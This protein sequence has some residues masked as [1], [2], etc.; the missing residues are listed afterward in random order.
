[1][2]A[3]GRSCRRS[4]DLAALVGNRR[5][6]SL[7]I[8]APLR[9][10][11]LPVGSAGGPRSRSEGAAAHLDLFGGPARARGRDACAV[12]TRTFRATRSG[13]RTRALRGARHL[14]VLDRFPSSPARAR[15]GTV[16]LFLPE[17]VAPDVGSLLE[18]AARLAAIAVEQRQLT[19]QL[20]PGPL[21]PADEPA[22]PPVPRG[23][24]ADAVSHAARRAERVTLLF[25]DLDRFKRVND[26]FGH[27]GGDALHAG[28]APSRRRGGRGDLVARMG[29]DEFCVLRVRPGALPVTTLARRLLDALDAPFDIPGE[30]VVVGASVGVSM[31]PDDAHDA[32]ALQM[33][34]DAAMYAAKQETGRACHLFQPGQTF[35]GGDRLRIDN[36]LRRAIAAG[37]LRLAFQPQADLDGL[38]KG[39]E[40]L[41]RWD[42][43][44]LGEVRPSRF[45]PIAE[46]SGLVLELG[47]WVIEDV[48]RRLAAWRRAG[49]P[50]VPISVNVSPVQFAGPDLVHAVEA[51]LA[52][53]GVPANL[54]RLEVTETALIKDSAATMILLGR[55]KNLGVGLAVDDFGT[56]YSSLVPAGPSDRRAEDRPGVHPRDRIGAAAEGAGPK[57]VQSLV[58]LGHSLGRRRR[59]GRRDGRAA[60]VPPAPRVRPRP[61]LR[62]RAA[63]GRR[64]LPAA[65]R[66]VRPAARAPAKLR[67]DGG[68]QVR[69]D[70]RRP[71]RSAGCS[72]GATGSRREPSA[73]AGGRCS[74]SPPLRRA[75][76]RLTGRWLAF[77]KVLGRVNWPSSCS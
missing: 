1:M 18:N 77:A 12:A 58:A 22:E 6:K 51:S 15:F 61:G 67:R 52:A 57:L 53:H 54:I 75:S 29:G 4:S 40:A 44:V 37:E 8:V 42:H 66:G 30:E 65:S 68:P 48:C 33:H 39:A 10:G 74:S 20:V 36:D 3:R 60:R 26:V 64:V 2:I 9:Q 59:R 76:S 72:S 17:P 28:G 32:M 38:L 27:S 47:R 11:V 69:M 71:T 23:G 25:V 35:R 70:G 73:A 5:P 34:A 43:P 46:E 13:N 63:D 14:R 24:G 41:V 45:V 49:L 7:C 21:R 31:Y 50:A 56:G 62:D 19:D 16:S 55:L